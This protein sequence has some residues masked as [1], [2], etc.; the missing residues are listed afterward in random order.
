MSRMHSSGRGKSG[1]KKPM[2]R[3]PSWAPYKEKEVEKLIIKAVKS[4]KSPSQTGMFLRDNYGIHDV[5]ALTEK[6]IG[7][8]LKE[9]NLQNELPE[10]L[11]CLIRKMIS[12]RQHLEKNK[13]DETGQRGLDLTN[14]K[15]RRL[16]KYYKQHKRLAA[17]WKLDMEKLKMYT[18]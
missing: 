12:I 9:N 18:G 16:V 8:I 11:L 5:R 1:S 17:G 15:I 2:K 7:T 14:S 13:H 3:V 10:D 4:G 6:R